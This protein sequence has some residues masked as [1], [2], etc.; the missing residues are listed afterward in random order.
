MFFLST[1]FA[2]LAPLCARFG[3]EFAD[4][5]GDT[6]ELRLLYLHT[7]TYGGVNHLREPWEVEK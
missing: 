5:S 2:T 3:P 4:V 7:P 1:K 6:N